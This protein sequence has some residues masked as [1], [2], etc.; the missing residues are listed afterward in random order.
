[1]NEKGKIMT[2]LGTA[3]PAA[4][5]RLYQLIP[6]KRRA[7]W[8]KHNGYA[9]TSHLALAAVLAGGGWKAFRH[10]ATPR[11]ARRQYGFVAAWAVFALTLGVGSS[12][13][14]TGP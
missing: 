6:P 12:W 9:S 13:T 2:N 11:Y 1:M 7:G 3:A 14:D 8:N 10:Y 5:I 4:V